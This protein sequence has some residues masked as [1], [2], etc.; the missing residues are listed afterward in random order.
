[1]QKIPTQH[2]HTQVVKFNVPELWQRINQS[3]LWPY[4]H[5]NE[6]MWVVSDIYKIYTIDFIQSI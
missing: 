4:S 2:T 1:M 5:L 6:D 3:D